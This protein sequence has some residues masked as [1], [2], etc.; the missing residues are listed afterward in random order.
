MIEL[1]LATRNRNKVRELEAL[2]SDMPVSISSMLDYP[3]I[4]DVEENGTTFVE[5]AT[6]KSE[7]A[8]KATGKMALADDSGLVVDALG[9]KPGVYSSRFA[10][11]DASDLD[12]CLK[13]LSMMEGIAD[14]LLESSLLITNPAISAPYKFGTKANR[15]LAE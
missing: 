9:G 13:I 3:E 15:V 14:D 11:E 1:V 4:P 6:L 7:A 12:K 10:G 2:L 5:N 8:A